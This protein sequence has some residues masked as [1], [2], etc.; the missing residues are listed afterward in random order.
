[1]ELRVYLVDDLISTHTL[2]KDLFA[3]IGPVRLV[4]TA[5]S[6]GEAR[7]W[8]EDHPGAWDLAVLDLVLESGSGM[9]LIGPCK[10]ANPQGQVAVFSGY[11]SPVLREH[12]L[13]LGADAV[14]NKA[15]SA[16][17]VLWLNEQVDP[18]GP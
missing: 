10:Q 3:A 8:L 9:A 2:M 18:H 16:D 4:A 6:E 1:L 13:R 7:L 12:C 5:S 11:V 15:D 17:F 14:F